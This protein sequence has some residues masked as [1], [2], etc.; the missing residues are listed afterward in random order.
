M[1]KFSSKEL[2]VT[3][4]VFVPQDVL[5]VEAKLFEVCFDDV[6]RLSDSRMDLLE[7]QVD[8]FGAGVA[9]RENLQVLG[10]GCPPCGP[11]F[12]GYRVA[13][14]TM[15]TSPARVDPQQ[16]LETEVLSQRP[17]K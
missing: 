6:Q 2:L 4:P 3:A 5:V 14:P 8:F 7:P 9:T 15:D 10:Y 11:Q 17:V 16:V 13:D 12:L 1:I